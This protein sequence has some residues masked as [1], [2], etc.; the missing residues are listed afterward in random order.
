MVL[1]SISC[2]FCGIFDLLRNVSSSWR[3]ILC[4]NL[5]YRRLRVREK[6]KLKKKNRGNLRHKQ[7]LTSW[8]T[9]WDDFSGKSGK[10]ISVDV[11]LLFLGG[12]LFFK[13]S[14]L[15]TGGSVLPSLI[16]HNVAASFLADTQRFCD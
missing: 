15:D 2:S 4:K 10:G 16:S 9:G 1:Y 6:D 12:F 7:T 14:S 13:Q 5:D 11:F 8:E 3:R